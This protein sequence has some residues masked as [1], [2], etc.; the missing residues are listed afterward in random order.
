M[1]AI[2]KR[3]NFFLQLENTAFKIGA[4]VLIVSSGYT[5]TIKA[6]TQEPW[7]ITQL[8]TIPR[9]N[10]SKSPDS[11]I[12]ETSLKRLYE[13]IDCTSYRLYLTPECHSLEDASAEFSELLE[14]QIFKTSENVFLVGH[15][16]GGLLFTHSISEHLKT[17]TNLVLVAPTYGCIMGDEMAFIRT[18]ERHISSNPFQSVD[19]LLFEVAMKSIG[20]RR[21]VDHDMSIGSDFVNTLDFRALKNHNVLLIAARC[22]E[23]KLCH[24]VDAFFRHYGKYI[25]LN[26]VGDGMVCY[27]NQMLPVA[28]YD[29]VKKIS[30]IQATH[31]RA[32][33]VA[34]PIII[35][36]ILNTLK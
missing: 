25:G 31:P 26:L 11:L 29:S 7:L 14:N 19:K 5:S 18:L 1:N 3:Q 8:K 22:P 35:N 23:Q 6:Q 20:S 4:P 28:Y 24:P 34:L 33:S 36:F 15:S 10:R 27:Y 30:S 21:P 16:K 9:R 2:V 13:K 12:M 32:F 17:S